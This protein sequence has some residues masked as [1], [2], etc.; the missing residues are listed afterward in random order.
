MSDRNWMM[1]K[2]EAKQPLNLSLLYLSMKLNKF[3]PLPRQGLYLT[4]DFYWDVMCEFEM[5]GSGLP[6]INSAP[7]FGL[8]N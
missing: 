5:H 6:F 7:V 8:H 1:K 2:N 4:V 3:S